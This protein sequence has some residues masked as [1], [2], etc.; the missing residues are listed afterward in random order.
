MVTRFLLLALDSVSSQPAAREPIMLCH[1]VPPQNLPGFPVLLKSKA[2]EVTEEDLGSVRLPPRTSASP[3]AS[4]FL[5]S[6][7]CLLYSGHISSTLPILFKLSLLLLLF[8][9]AC[10]CV[11]VCMCACCVWLCVCV[12]ARF[13][14]VMFTLL[15]EDCVNFK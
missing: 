2:L 1:A 9:L 11:Y 14:I 7:S 13:S 8:L 3:W 12:R 5:C 4:G 15:D 10:T 6:R